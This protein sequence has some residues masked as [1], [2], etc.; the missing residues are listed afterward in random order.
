M[1]IIAAECLDVDAIVG[2]EIDVLCDAVDGD[3]HII[4]K[5]DGVVAAGAG[6]HERAISRDGDARCATASALED[7]DVF[8]GMISPS[9]C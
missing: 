5:I 8:A 4:F 1:V 7:A 9:G 2:V 3:L 6:D